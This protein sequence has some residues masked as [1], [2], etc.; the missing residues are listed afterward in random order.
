M[1][2]ST[3]NKVNEWARVNVP[4]EW[5]YNSRMTYW[6]SARNAGLITSEQFEQARIYYGSLWQYVG[7]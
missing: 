4:T 1:D 6:R 7:D 3:I 2:T 5:S